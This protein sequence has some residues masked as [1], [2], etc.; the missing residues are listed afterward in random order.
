MTFLREC[1]S[2][3]RFGEETL[4]SLWRLS[5]ALGFPDVGCHSKFL[6]SISGNLLNICK[7]F[8][9]IMLFTSQTSFLSLLSRLHCCL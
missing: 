4:F 5:L 7:T 3:L 1:L 8:I 6:L 9:V 2:L